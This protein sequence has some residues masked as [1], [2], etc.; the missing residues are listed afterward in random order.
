MTQTDLHTLLHIPKRSQSALVKRL[1]HLQAAWD[2]HEYIGQLLAQLADDMDPEVL[3]EALDHNRAGRVHL[4]A[5]LASLE[6]Q[7]PRENDD[8]DH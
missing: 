4:V 1:A 7:F 5:Y 8:A 2:H 3:A 6:P